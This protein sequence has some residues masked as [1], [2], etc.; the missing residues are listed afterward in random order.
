MSTHHA[1]VLTALGA[2]LV[3]GCAELP[4]APTVSPQL[5]DVPAAV[6]PAN[7]AS[8]APLHIVTGGGAFE[9]PQIPGFSPAMAVHM[10]VS[11]TMLPD[12]SVR[13]TVVSRADLTPF[14][15]GYPTFSMNVDCLAV[16]ANTA[17][18]S[19][20]TSHSSGAYP[21]VGEA[22]IGVIVD[23][24]RT[25]L[26]FSGPTGFWAPGKTCADMPDLPQLPVSSGGYAVR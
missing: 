2:L 23:N 22:G 10:S 26:A 19:G 13:G 20:L 18:F 12:G 7:P 17:W 8:H 1:S 21:A 11:I 9:M 16:S 4:S 5:T 3:A 14:G 6:I 25:D 24:G 15:L